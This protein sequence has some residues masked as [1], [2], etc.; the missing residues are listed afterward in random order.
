MQFL[1]DL[2]TAAHICEPMWATVTSSQYYGL[3]SKLS[4][5]A[6]R[7]FLFLFLCPWQGLSDCLPLGQ[8]VCCLN[9]VAY[10]N[11]A[12]P[13]TA[14]T[15]TWP[16]QK[17]IS[18]TWIVTLCLCSCLDPR[19]SLITFNSLVKWFFILYH[20][21]GWQWFLPHLLQMRNLIIVPVT[22]LWWSILCGHWNGPWG[23]QSFDHALF[24]NYLRGCS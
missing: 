15:S 10:R 13:T 3:P 21:V 16:C 11:H 4:P 6:K 8:Y 5:S 24:G 12:T 14:A 17:C 20:P 19:V 2:L 22:L 18:C 9:G 1:W 23:V 7:R